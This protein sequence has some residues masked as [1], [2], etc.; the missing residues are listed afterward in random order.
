MK[1]IGVVIVGAAGNRGRSALEILPKLSAEQREQ[2]IKLE[3]VCVAEA[4]EECR[5]A[6]SGAVETLFGCGCPVVSTLG[7]AI[8]HALRWLANGGKRKLAVYDAAP[9]ALHYQHLMS[10]LPHSERGI[11][12]F[13]EKPLF[14]NEGQIEFIERNFA[15][16]TF[17]CEFIET[18]N[19][20]FRAA[21]DYIFSERFKIE[22]MSFWRASCMGVS[23]AA[24]LGRG[25]VEGGAL[26]D[27]APHDLS[28]AIGLLGLGSLKE[29]SV[30]AVR[31][32]LLALHEDAIRLHER[33][34][35]SVA[36]TPLED[37]NTHARI[38][39]QLPAE[40]Q[41]SFDVDFRLEGN[42]LIPASFLASW[43]GLQ[44]SAPEMSFTQKL[45]GLGIGPEEWLNN[46][47]LR[48]DRKLGDRYRNQEVR[49]MLI[50]GS[51]GNREAHLIVNLLAKY[52]GR[53]FVHVVGRDR[54]R[55]IIFEEQNGRDYHESKDADLFRVFKGVVEHCAGFRTAENVS[56]RVTL[57][58]HKIM[59]SAQTKANEQLQSIDQD[60][61]YR[62]S[63]RAYTKYFMPLD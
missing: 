58:V 7:E 12:Y 54:R 51:L 29:W 52:E 37:L 39:E 11:F 45:V 49:V 50:D 41:M 61:A 3:L 8:P 22:R 57:L 55:E 33:R 13:G 46:E 10:V 53:R 6:L 2:G 14:T 21:R 20:A 47:E 62:A 16:R 30:R 56:T 42:I 34:F 9:T 38:P 1:E 59:L 43:V 19:P 23:I 15:E 4:K 27:K 26:Q 63:L 36:N 25:G 24:G 28:V 60:E 48:A 32:H 44:N 40:A 18:E 35:L 17:F 31:T 5:A